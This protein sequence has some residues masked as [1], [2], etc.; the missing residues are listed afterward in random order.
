M[1][2]SLSSNGFLVVITHPYKSR[3]TIFNIFLNYDPVFTPE[4]LGG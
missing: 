1:A 3:V 2:N 4:L